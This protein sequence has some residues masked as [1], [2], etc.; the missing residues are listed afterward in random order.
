MKLKK[1][2]VVKP[3][4][5]RVEKDE[6]I[7]RMDNF[8]SDQMARDFEQREDIKRLGEKIDALGR[9]IEDYVRRVDEF[10]EAVEKEYKKEFERKYD[11]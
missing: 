9:D 6:L 3:Y 11:R 5:Y 4:D 7:A 1:I 8:A 10:C 2:E